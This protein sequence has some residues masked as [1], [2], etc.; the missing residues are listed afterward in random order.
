M[1]NVLRNLRI[2]D[3]IT[4][5]SINKCQLLFWWANNWSFY[6]WSTAKVL[7][8]HNMLFLC[9]FCFYQNQLETYPNELKQRH[10]HNQLQCNAFSN[11]QHRNIA[12]L[13][14]KQ[15]KNCSKTLKKKYSQLVKWTF[16][17]LSPSVVY[18][19]SLK[20]PRRS[21]SVFPPPAPDMMLLL[22][23]LIL[24]NNNCFPTFSFF[25]ETCPL[26]NTFSTGIHCT[27][28][29]GSRQANQSK[30]KCIKPSWISKQTYYYWPGLAIKCCLSTIIM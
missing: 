28:M 19:T 24:T 5:K 29:K 3:I 2:S 23:L 8:A 12:S 25:K 27:L 14:T 21:I 9:Q 6:K 26:A 16:G 10:P 11:T 20:R 13:Q 30:N 7:Y 17:Y 22:W 15:A 18:P 4:G 1:N